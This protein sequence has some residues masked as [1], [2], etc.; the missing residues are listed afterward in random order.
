MAT[1]GEKL[2]WPFHT[3]THVDWCTVATSDEPTTWRRALASTEEGKEEEGWGFRRG[4]RRPKSS[5]NVVILEGED[6]V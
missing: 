2:P 5:N 3:A 1:D 6:V 4:R